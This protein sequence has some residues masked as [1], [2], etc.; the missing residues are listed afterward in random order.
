MEKSAVEDERYVEKKNRGQY[1]KKYSGMICQEIQ[2][3]AESKRGS[4]CVLLG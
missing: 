4:N 1:F 2:A 3:V